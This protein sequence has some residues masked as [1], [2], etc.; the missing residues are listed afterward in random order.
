MD[1]TLA[2]DR[3]LVADAAAWRAWLD[4]HESSSDGIR[5]VLAKKG[6]TE[7]TSLTY[8]EALEEALCSG[9][10]DGR[11]NALDEFTFQ[12]HFTPRR[13]TSI[14]S[15]RNVDIVARLIAEGRMRERGHAEIDRAKAD[16]RWERAY[17]GQADAQVPEDLA[18]AL[19]E[20]PRASVYF[21]SLTRAD[22]YAAI[23]QVITAV[24][25]TTRANRIGRLVAGWG[26]KG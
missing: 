22:Q 3:L 21:E 11:R 24:S 6:V 15:Q 26:R 19:A 9:W 4:A 7:P 17:S 16:G 14:W 20:S 13:K 8:A 23:H 10:I 25:P 12:Q 5:L 1:L 2:A 18:A